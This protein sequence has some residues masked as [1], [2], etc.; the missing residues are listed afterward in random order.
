MNV[1]LRLL[2]RL[3]RARGM[4]KRILLLNTFFYKYFEF[5]MV[6]PVEFLFVCLL[7]F[8]CPSI[9][10]NINWVSFNW[11]LYIFI[12]I[13]YYHLND[14]QKID[15]MSQF[16]ANKSQKCNIL[17]FIFL[18]VFF[19]CW[20]CLTINTELW[21]VVDNLLYFVILIGLLVVLRVSFGRNM[22]FLVA[23]KSNSFIFTKPFAPFVIEF[24]INDF[25]FTFWLEMCF[26]FVNIKQK[27]LP[28][29]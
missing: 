15:F 18:R 17:T 27:W 28:L 5:F 12:C 11:F 13:C 21:V 8:Q 23:Y 9:L 26:F 2:M 14:I 24:M 29:N 22:V 10:H 16:D 3:K 6:L 1:K 25:Y 20:C 19:C 4:L 7:Y